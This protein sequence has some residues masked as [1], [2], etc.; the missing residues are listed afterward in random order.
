MNSWKGEFLMTNTKNK[1]NNTKKLLGAVGMLSISAAMLVS[2]TFAWF[3]MNKDVKATSM[4]VKAKAE[5]GLLINE[6]AT[7]GNEF[8]DDEATANEAP[9]TAL[10]PTSTT[11]AAKW[12]HANSKIAS[13]EAGAGAN[14]KSTNLSG[15][16][17]ELT[18][19]V[20]E[21]STATAGS[22]AANSIFYKNNDGTAGYSA[23]STDTAYYV[24]YKYYL[25]LSNENGMNNL[26]QTSGAQNVAIKSVQVTQPSTPGSPDLNKALRVG[27]KIGGKMYIYA[28]LYT[29]SAAPA[30]YYATT[31][32][33]GTTTQTITN[34]EVAAFT[35][36]TAAYTALTTLPGMTGAGTEVDV[37]VWFEGEDPNCKSE[38]ITT[39]LDDIKVDITFS[40][41]TMDSTTA[42]AAAAVKT[43]GT[44]EF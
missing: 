11:N 6:V 20:S 14:Q 8:W 43:A 33:S 23:S 15:D 40:L 3:T 44:N 36:D 5:A 13:D 32:I 9:G 10:V 2:S 7:A 18:S 28:P 34:Q 24:M 19:L 42:A 27:I 17:E 29:S 31:A 38:N 16:Y 30:A 21:D 37:Y 41:V 25:R 22:V 1:K 4:Q 12:F 26:A 39:T 35:G